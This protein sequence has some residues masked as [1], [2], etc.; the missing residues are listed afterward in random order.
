[1]WL[2]HH[3]AL[4]YKA[5]AQQFCNWL[6]PA[7]KVLSLTRLKTKWLLSGYGFASIKGQTILLYEP[8]FGDLNALIF[9]F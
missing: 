4:Y 5:L 7:D 9:L 6:K 3:F 1:M 8:V 2:Y